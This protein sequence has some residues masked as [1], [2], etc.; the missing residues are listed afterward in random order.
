MSEE[1]VK[2]KKQTKKVSKKIETLGE[3]SEKVKKSLKKKQIIPD[4]SDEEVLVVRLPA[5]VIP[6]NDNIKP[7]TPE[8][9]KL[10]P[11]ETI[12]EPDDSRQAAIPPIN[13]PVKPPVKTFRSLIKTTPDK[14]DFMF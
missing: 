5:P 8:P 14:F 1:E 4:D 10:I 3:K 13:P 6:T 7:N 11:I 9:P 2:P 12:K